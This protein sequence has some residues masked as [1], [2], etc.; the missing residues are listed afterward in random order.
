MSRDF[1]DLLAVE[2]TEEEL[3]VLICGPDE[4]MAWIGMQL[5]KRKIRPASS[6]PNDPELL[7]RLQ[8]QGIV[9]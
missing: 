7:Q 1:F 3:L 8:E 4:R 2:F 9:T 5:L 6:E